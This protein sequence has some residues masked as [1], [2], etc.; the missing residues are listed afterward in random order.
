MQVASPTSNQ[1]EPI[2]PKLTGQPQGISAENKNLVF[3]CSVFLGEQ[4][5]K[6]LVSNVVRDFPFSTWQVFKMSWYV[7]DFISFYGVIK[8]TPPMLTLER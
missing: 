7:T 4:R 1:I 5:L 6:G 2:F 8:S 3:H